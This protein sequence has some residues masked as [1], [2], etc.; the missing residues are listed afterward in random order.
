MTFFLVA[1]GQQAGKLF[2]QV[3]IAFAIPERFNAG[4]V[5]LGADVLS[6]QLL[7]PVG[8]IDH[9]RLADIRRGSDLLHQG[10]ELFPGCGLL[11]AAHIQK[12]SAPLRINEK[13]FWALRG[14]TRFTDTLHA[15]QH[16]FLRPGNPAR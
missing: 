2:C 14:E 9:Q 3:G 6:R 13:R 10:E 8:G 1:G 16:H 7:R 15:V 11:Q 12:C 4:L 5:V